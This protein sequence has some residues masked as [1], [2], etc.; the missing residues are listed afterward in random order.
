MGEIRFRQGKYDEAARQFLK[1]NYLYGYKEWKA[2]SLYMAAQ[3][4][5][6]LDK[7]AQAKKYYEL[8]IKTYPDSDFSAKAKASLGKL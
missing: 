3:S 2:V 1:V 5:Q 4:F 7:K 8:L 6:K